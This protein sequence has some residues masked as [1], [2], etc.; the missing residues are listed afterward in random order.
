MAKLNLEQ[1]KDLAATY[2]WALAVLRSNSELSALFNRAIN[3]GYAPARFIAELRATSWY[4]RHSEANR[5]MEILKKVDP[6]EYQRRRAKMRAD[7]AQQYYRLTGRKTSTTGG[8][9]VTLWNFADQAL[10]F[11]YNESEI[12]DLV[13]RMVMSQ[14]LMVHGGLGG[15]LGEAERQLRQ[16]M[17]DY[18]LGFSET[19]LARQL[20]SIATQNSDIT[21]TI[22]YYRKMA[23]QRYAA[24]ADEIRQGMT[25]KDIAEPYRQMM[26]KT[27][28]ISDKSL[29]VND[30]MIQKALMFRAPAKSGAPGPPTGMPLWQFEQT[31]KNDPRWLKTQNAQDSIMSVGRQVLQDF[32]LMAGRS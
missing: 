6:A 25:V 32:G 29:N 10:N 23:M 2:G 28:E 20:N 17:E 12:T 3:G 19:A 7:M 13:G 8:P 21:S 30:S 31:L 27:L 11:G 14:N 24:F 22:S 5:Q 26:A 4:R 1:Q 15:T 16:A 18:G 9:G